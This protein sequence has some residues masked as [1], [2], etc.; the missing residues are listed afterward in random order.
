MLPESWEMRGA[1]PTHCALTESMRELLHKAKTRAWGH[2]LV[3]ESVCFTY[4]NTGVQ[5]TSTQKKSWSAMP[6]LWGDWEETKVFMAT[7]LSPGP[8]SDYLKGIS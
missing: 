8:V 1:A 2:H 3:S 6:V 5:I 7:S 4:T